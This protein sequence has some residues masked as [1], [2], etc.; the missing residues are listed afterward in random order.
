MNF[1][2]VTWVNF[3]CNSSKLPEACSEDYQDINEDTVTILLSS[4]TIKGKNRPFQARYIVSREST[5]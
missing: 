3:N 2:H 1:S 5:I 4:M